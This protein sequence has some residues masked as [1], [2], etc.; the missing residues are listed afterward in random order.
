MSADTNRSVSFTLTAEDYAVANQLYV[1][2]SYKGGVG[3]IV[4]A[5]I[6]LLFG[7]FFGS[8]DAG[9]GSYAWLAPFF[10]GAAIVLLALPFVSYFLL[11]PRSARK[12]YR[13]QKSLQQPLTFS[14]SP[15]GLKVTSEAG[16]WLTPWDHYL[17]RAENDEILLF[18]Q[19]PRLFQMLPKRALTPEQVADLR[20]CAIGVKG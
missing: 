17:R 4:L 9:G 15:A 2:K 6:L 18:Y 7:R 13:Q 3:I 11:A 20:E 10:Y 5:G 1:L 19:S 12:I 16:E 14:W 8:G